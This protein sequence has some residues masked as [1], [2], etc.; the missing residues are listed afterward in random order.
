MFDSEKRKQLM[1][2]N[3]GVKNS[4]NLRMKKNLYKNHLGM[5]MLILHLLKLLEPP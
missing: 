1:N 3:R 4:L 2:K 5:M